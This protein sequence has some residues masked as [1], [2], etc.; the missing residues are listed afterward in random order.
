MFFRIAWAGFARALRTS[1][2]GL[3]TAFRCSSGVRRRAKNRSSLLSVPRTELV[4]EPLKGPERVQPVPHS[5]GPPDWVR[6]G[7]INRPLEGLPPPL[8]DRR[9]PGEIAQKRANETR[10][11]PLLLHRDSVGEA[12][13]HR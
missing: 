10:D 13:P 7:P 12:K 4:H 9:Q 2:S 11:R 5:F 3:S 6:L 8:V 1:R